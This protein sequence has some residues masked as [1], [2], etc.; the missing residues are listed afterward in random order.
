MAAG[1][2]G[3]YTQIGFLLRLQAGTDRHRCTEGPC[4]DY[5]QAQINTDKLR[6]LEARRGA[7]NLLELRGQVRERV[8]IYVQIGNVYKGTVTCT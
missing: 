2:A 6:G 3:R 4:Q 7:H 5:G 8:K 1:T